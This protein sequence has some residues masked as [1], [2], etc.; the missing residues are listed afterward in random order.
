MGHSHNGVPAVV[1]IKD[2][3][4]LCLLTKENVRDTT[5]CFEKAGLQNSMNY[6]SPFMKDCTCI[7]LFL[8]H[9]FIECLA[10]FL[11]PGEQQ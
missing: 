1:N 6:L 3:G 7:Y 9:V 10:P 5:L 11:A 2:D 8:Q 4:A